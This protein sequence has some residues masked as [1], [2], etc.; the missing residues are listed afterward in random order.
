MWFEL[1][2]RHLEKSGFFI[3]LKAC[4]TGFLNGKTASPKFQ[5]SSPGRRTW[6]IFNPWKWSTICW[7]KWKWDELS[8]NMLKER[9]TTLRVKITTVVRIA[10]ENSQALVSLKKYMPP[11]LPYFK[12]NICPLPLLLNIFLLLVIL[13][14]TQ[15][16]R[17]T[18]EI[19]LFSTATFKYIYRAPLRQI[20]Q[21]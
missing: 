18:P 1:K 11:P 7:L 5:F 4:P 3:L 19:F 21:E 17:Y 2:T 20:G 13:S 9:T 14:L 6:A 15:L 10:K 16:Y 8:S 12:V